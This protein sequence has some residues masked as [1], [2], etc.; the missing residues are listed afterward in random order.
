MADDP[1]DNVRELKC[2]HYFESGSVG[3]LVHAH[4]WLSITH[5]GHIR[6]ELDDL[7][8]L[9]RRVFGEKIHIYV[10]AS[11]SPEVAYRNYIRKHQG[12]MA[13]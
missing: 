9:A 3:G 1:R 2:E 5:V 8:D 11:S 6:I 13:M 12:A 4:I 7:R 10:Q